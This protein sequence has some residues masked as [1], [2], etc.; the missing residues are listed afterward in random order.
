MWKNQRWR[1]VI[2][3][4]SLDTSTIETILKINFRLVIKNKLANDIIDKN[5]TEW[6][7]NKR[8]RVRNMKKYIEGNVL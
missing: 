6:I 1:L 5:E 3:K 2:L 8:H 4:I 7:Y